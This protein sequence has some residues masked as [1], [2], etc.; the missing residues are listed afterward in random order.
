MV[1]AV[2]FFCRGGV[3]MA[4]VMWRAAGAGDSRGPDGAAGRG[5]R[6]LWERGGAGGNGG[7]H[8]HSWTGQEVHIT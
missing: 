5:S 4:G 3:F 7:G 6:S 8:W 1:L 2:F